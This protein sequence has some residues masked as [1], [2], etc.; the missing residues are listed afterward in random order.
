M[1][2]KLILTALGFL[3]R[4]RMPAWVPFDP[5]SVACAARWFAL[6]GL[7]L[8]ALAAGLLWLLA[9]GL[10]QPLA[11]VL[12][13]ILLLLLTGAFHEDGLADTFD[14]FWGGWERQRKL[15][16]MKDSQIGTYGVLSLI[17]C[18]AIKAVALSQLHLGL[19]MVALLASHAGG[20]TV[21]GLVPVLLPYARSDEGSKTP[22]RQRS[23]GFGD[24]LA[25]MAC[26]AAPLLLLPQE[27]AAVVALVWA[28]AFGFMSWLMHR[29]I[30]GYT[31]D[32]LGATEQVTECLTLIALV[33]MMNQGW[34]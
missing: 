20:R 19:A 18:L 28:G 16:I 30:R 7:L 17:G 33:A 4:L 5:D 29:H 13:L 25:L 21:A 6:I 27:A 32:T 24:Q 23:P 22:Q 15:A 10:G 12:V 1:N 11:V 8:G 26:G 2:P 3:T 31:G 9:P 14:G 34:L